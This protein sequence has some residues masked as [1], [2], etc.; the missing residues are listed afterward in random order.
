MMKETGEY[1]AY[2]PNKAWYAKE[3]VKLIVVCL[4]VA[5]L[6]YDRLL[7]APLLFPMG[8]YIWK[9]DRAKYKKG[10]QNTLRQEF[11]ELIVML[12][13]SLN[14]GYSMEQALRKACEDMVNEG[15]FEYIPK[16]LALVIN[17]IN[18]NRDVDKL[19]VEMGERCQEN[20][21]IEFARLVATAKKY[22]GNINTLIDKTKRKLNDKLMVEREI[23]TLISAKRLE[24]SIMLVMPFVI[25]LY[26]RFTNESYIRLLYDSFSGNVI[27]TVALIMVMVCGLIIKKIT[28]IEV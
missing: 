12:S 13:G 27:V 9:G 19:L 15:G 1:Y 26:M 17:G 7:M 4:G 2:K 24:G 25:M 10:V 20:L 14:A 22:G 21:I 11:K 6:M 18:L 5:V 28:E 16:E 23:D 3:V 8:I